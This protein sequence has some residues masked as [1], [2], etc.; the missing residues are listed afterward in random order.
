MFSQQENR[1][2]I[3]VA[4]CNLNQWAMDFEGNR[5]RVIQSLVEAR[6]SGATFRVGPELE[7]S[8]YS[9][10]DHFL[11]IDTVNHCW[12]VLGQILEEGYTKDI[13]CTFGMPV[14]HRG[15]LYNCI[16][17]VYFRDVLL[18]RPK[19]AIS[20]EGNYREGRFFTPWL[21]DEL[22]DFSLPR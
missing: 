9:C 16:V 20:D 17:V 7:L 22:E 14:L 19:I 21:K 11:E 3:K 2:I 8:G 6:R 15:V 18:I 10:E 5:K 1:S 12:E 13:L 4:T